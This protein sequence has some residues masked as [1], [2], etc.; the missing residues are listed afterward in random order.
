[1]NKNELVQKTGRIEGGRVDGEELALINAQTLRPLAADEV[2]AFRVCA[3]DNQ[4]DRDFERFTE[5]S[6]TQLAELY[7]GRTMLVDHLWSATAQTARV[8]AASVEAGSGGVQRLILRAYLLRTP[9]SAPTIAAIEAGILREVSVACAVKRRVCSICG[10]AEPEAYCEHVPGRIYGGQV[11]HMDLEDVDDAYE[12]SFVAVPA[13]REAGVVKDGAQA[14]GRAAEKERFL[15]A[16]R[17]LELEEK[18]YG[19]MRK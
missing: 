1:M 17:R 7:V 3:C 4:V 5:S 13:Q 9:Q 10:A 12:V 8:Y 6:L 14:A 15:R 16:V 18:R 11:C 2:F 19:G